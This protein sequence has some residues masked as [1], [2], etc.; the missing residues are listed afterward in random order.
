MYFS[1]EWIFRSPENVEPKKKTKEARIWALSGQPADAKNLDFSS[2]KGKEVYS[3]KQ[4]VSNDC[5]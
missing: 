5:L 1:K 4:R 3:I 2:D